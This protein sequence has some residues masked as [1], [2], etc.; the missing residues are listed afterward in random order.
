M[1]SFLGL[2]PGPEYKRV[3]TVDPLG[4]AS[5]PSSSKIDQ[6]STP[7]KPRSWTS[8]VWD[9][10]DKPVAERRFLFKLDACLLTY[11]ALSYFSK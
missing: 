4:T 8:Y 11:A 1:L 5:M 9:T 6:S 2:S 3:P 10:W 7:E